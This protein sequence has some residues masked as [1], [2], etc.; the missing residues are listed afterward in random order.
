MFQLPAFCR[1]LLR[2]EY[3]GEI[4]QSDF[5][6]LKSH[7]FGFFLVS[8]LFSQFLLLIQDT[9]NHAIRDNSS[10]TG[11]I[12]CKQWLPAACERHQKRA[13]S[14]M[15]LSALEGHIQ[16]AVWCFAPAVEA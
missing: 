8:D 6:S 4:F 5:L 13:G 15:D 14:L 3:L 11:E 7:D 1:F 12:I 9:D 10:V 2:S 16:A